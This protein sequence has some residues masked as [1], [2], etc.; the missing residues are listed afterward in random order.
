M[1]DLTIT[2]STDFRQEKRDA[3]R[4]LLYI[5]SQRKRIKFNITVLKRLDDIIGSLK[6][7]AGEQDQITVLDKFVQE[8]GIQ[9]QLTAGRAPKMATRWGKYFLLTLS[10]GMVTSI[11][12]E[13]YY[14]TIGLGRPLWKSKISDKIQGMVND[15]ELF[16]AAP[17]ILIEWS[18]IDGDF[19]M[20]QRLV[21]ANIDPK[22]IEDYYNEYQANNEDGAKFS[23]GYLSINKYASI[24]KRVADQEIAKQQKLIKDIDE[25]LNVDGDWLSK[26][27][28]SRQAELVKQKE[29][30][31]KEKDDTITRLQGVQNFSEQVFNSL[32]VAQEI[33]T[34]KSK[35]L[36]GRSGTMYPMKELIESQKSLL[37]WYNGYIVNECFLLKQCETLEDFLNVLHEI[38]TE[39]LSGEDNRDRLRQ[40]DDEITRTNIGLLVRVKVFSDCFVSKF[41]AVKP[42]FD[43]L[44]RTAFANL[45]WWAY[46]N[47]EDA[48]IPDL[49]KYAFMATAGLGFMS[50]A[51]L[52]D[53]VIY[54]KKW[55][56]IGDTLVI[57]DVAKSVYLS[58]QTIYRDA[59]NLNTEIARLEGEPA[60]SNSNMAISVYYG[61][62]MFH[63]MLNVWT[64]GSV[65]DIHMR[66]YLDYDIK[67]LFLGYKLT[68]RG[69][70]IL[71]FCVKIVQAK[72]AI[73]EVMF[74]VG[75]EAIKKRK[76]S[77]SE[78]KY[79]ELQK[80]NE[81]NFTKKLINLATEFGP[82]DP[83]WGDGMALAKFEALQ[84][85]I[86]T[87]RTVTPDK[88]YTFGLTAGMDKYYELEGVAIIRP[89]LKREKR[90]GLEFP[91][92]T[93]VDDTEMLGGY[94][95]RDQG[96]YTPIVTLKAE[97]FFS[98]IDKG[99]SEDDV[100]NMKYPGYFIAED[101]EGARSVYSK[102]MIGPLNRNF[103][104][105]KQFLS[106]FER[107]T[108][109]PLEIKTTFK[110]LK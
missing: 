10:A 86:M 26:P 92:V 76:N 49:N 101:L 1:S 102:D 52:L 106:N 107:V 3:V 12:T 82:N 103:D 2:M 73:Y 25:E 18:S 79:D 81:D 4:A 100:E 108:L 24:Y 97:K 23:D 28:A 7:A 59:V 39:A 8:S 57:D 110:K 71:D 64:K 32:K 99:V 56:I 109:H 77:M 63:R 68:K 90:D 48:P 95:L 91:Y 105:F 69:R 51:A 66:I 15:I 16:Q 72:V 58:D 19:N 20:T 50:L 38:F 37:T 22:F 80:K 9:K 41:P 89:F 11:V 98:I 78:E 104:A 35:K 14:S 13:S 46:T 33:F 84:T 31:L 75:A 54:G 42:F 61:T 88:A 27:W 74:K 93:K 44:Y 29:R 6:T 45:S 85:V 96:K 53:T 40:V 17:D 94:Y 34:V 83:V 70:K 5:D 43:S 65:S 62:Q 67:G 47:D 87:L 55:P 21:D 36:T 30:V 60:V